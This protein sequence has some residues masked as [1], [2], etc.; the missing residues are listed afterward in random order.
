MLF[1]EKFTSKYYK[2]AFKQRPKHI[3]NCPDVEKQYMYCKKELKAAGYKVDFTKV[4]WDYF[5]DTNG[6]FN[7]YNTVHFYDIR[8]LSK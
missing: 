8:K 4:Q 7:L 1:S 6:S 5:T 3:G 2:T